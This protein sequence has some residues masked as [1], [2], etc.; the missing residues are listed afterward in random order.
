[1]LVEDVLGH[2][3]SRGL[4]GSRVKVALVCWRVWCLHQRLANDEDVRAAALL[5]RC[6]EELLRLQE[7]VGRSGS[8]DVNHSD[9]QRVSC[10]EPN[11]V[12]VLVFEMWVAEVGQTYLWLVRRRSFGVRANRSSAAGVEVLVDAGV[13]EHAKRKGAQYLRRAKRPGEVCWSSTFGRRFLVRQK[14]LRAVCSTAP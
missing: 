10:W 2:G 12:R 4:H 13:A 6:S 3:N 5:R 1:L 11:R 8:S 9:L 14:A 7:A